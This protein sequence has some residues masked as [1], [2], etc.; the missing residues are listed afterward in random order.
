MCWPTAC[1]N[2][3]AGAMAEPFRL[4]GWAA[5]PKQPATLLVL[6]DGVEIQRVLLADKALLFGRKVPDEPNRGTMRLDHDS[7]SREHAV[8]VNSFTGEIFL[9]D[10]QSRYGTKLDGEP[11]K[12]RAYQP[13]KD[14][15]QMQFGESTRRFIVTHRPPP[16]P[17]SGSAALSSAASSG[18]AKAAVASGTSSSAAPSGHAGAARKEEDDEVDPMAGYRASRPHP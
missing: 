4:P 11:L 12:P 5:R 2:A 14:G 3:G 7:I 13:L 6:K 15:Q 8:I 10:L 1:A 17:R 9:S 16:P 18:K